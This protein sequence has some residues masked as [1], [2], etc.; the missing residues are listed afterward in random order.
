MAN[1]G[2]F[3]KP[4]RDHTPSP[5]SGDVI[6]DTLATAAKYGLTHEV[7]LFSLRDAFA[8]GYA[9]AITKSEGGRHIRVAQAFHE[10]GC[11]RQDLNATA[12]LESGLGEWVK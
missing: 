11:F 12:A 2:M 5:Y 10:H 9:S 4:G 6:A 7:V 1:S 3:G 8:Q